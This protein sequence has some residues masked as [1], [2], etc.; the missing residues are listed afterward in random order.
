MQRRVRVKWQNENYNN[1]QSP[2]IIICT[3]RKSCRCVN[4]FRIFAAMSK[5]NYD[6]S[7]QMQ[8]DL[9]KAYCKA[10]AEG[11][12]TMFD[13]CAK[14]VKMPAPRFYVSAKQAYQ[15]ISPMVKGDFERVDLFDPL[16]R[17]M[18]YELFDIVMKLTEKREFIGKSLWHIMPFAVIQPASRFFIKPHSLY[19]I[20]QHI[21]TGK[22]TEEGK[23]PPHLNMGK[24][25]KK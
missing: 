1:S 5:N 21:K 17:Q 4:V 6:I 11:S 20:R 9:I 12:W 10:C 24:R 8:D 23:Q 18:Y 15:I 13:A 2:I 16:R 14:A 22:M 3:K 19:V 25:K 7:R